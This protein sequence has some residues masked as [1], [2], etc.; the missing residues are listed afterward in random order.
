VNSV[1]ILSRVKPVTVSVQ[2]FCLCTM[3]CYITIFYLS[4]VTD[5]YIL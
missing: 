5:I 3:H 1:Y 2:L 4:G